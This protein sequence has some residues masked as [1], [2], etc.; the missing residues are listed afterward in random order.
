MD[1]H[2]ETTSATTATGSL[3]PFTPISGLKFLSS[4]PVRLDDATLAKVEAVAAAPLPA[5]PPCDDRHMTQC[6]GILDAAL[7]RQSAGEANGKLR[8]AA[9]K[10]KL[11]HLPAEAISYLA[12]QALDRCRW[13]P[14]IAE[15]VEIVSEWKRSD[16]PVQA[17]ARA[18]A[19]ARRERE[20]RMD[21]AMKALQRGDLDDD[22]VNAWPEAWQ[23]IAE[24]RALITIR[25]GRCSIRPSAIWHSEVETDATD[26]MRRA[27][28]QFPSQREA[29]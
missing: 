9:Y 1:Q 5:L 21:D 4:L 11:A 19:I 14:T 2:L 29:A 13:F 16:E 3:A 24:T 25:E 28:E 8:L 26:A 7:P 12:D 15:C 6:L 18:Q 17:K 20:A 22:A 27:A 23:R 10:R